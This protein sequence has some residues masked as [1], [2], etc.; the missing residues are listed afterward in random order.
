MMERVDKTTRMSGDERR[1]Q[2][3]KVAIS[4]FSRKGFNG[5]TTKEIAESAGVSEATLFKH[6]AN[7]HELYNAI[8]DY[9]SCEAGIEQIFTL[10]EEATQRDLDEKDVFYQ[11]MLQILNYHEKDE[12]F[13]RLLLHSA[14]DG[15]EFAQ[16]FVSRKIAPLY[17]SMSH[18]INGRQKKRILRGDLPAQL[19]VRAFI[20]MLI[21]HSM[22]KLLWDKE[23]RLVKASNEEVANVFSE[24]LLSGIRNGDKKR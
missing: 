15:H 23:Q 21:H 8:L 12:E 22:N 11:M 1:I 20:G 6:F 9:K 2:L 13:L 19:I 16:L 14:L 18:Y 3:I 7:K 24:I 5:T 17:E 4:L 10:F